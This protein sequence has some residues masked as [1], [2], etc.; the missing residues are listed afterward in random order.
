MKKTPSIL[1]TINKTHPHS[2]RQK[3]SRRSVM[4]RLLTVQAYHQTELLVDKRHA[5]PPKPSLLNLNHPMSMM[6]SRRLNWN[7]LMIGKERNSRKADTSEPPRRLR[8]TV[9]TSGG[10]RERHKSLRRRLGFNP[11]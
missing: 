6:I 4:S 5:L 1:L 10:A 3:R 7:K 11:T 8:G 9:H 2:V